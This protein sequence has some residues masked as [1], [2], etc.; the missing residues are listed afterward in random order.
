MVPL[1]AAEPW[2]KDV[3]EIVGKQVDAHDRDQNGQSWGQDQGAPRR[4]QMDF[5]HSE[6]R[7]RKERTS[8]STGLPCGESQRG[9]KHAGKAGT[10]GRR[11]RLGRTRKTCAIRR[12]PYG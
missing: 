12:K 4:R 1:P 6:R 11:V 7:K 9:P 2:V 5:S 10:A 3:P 8:R